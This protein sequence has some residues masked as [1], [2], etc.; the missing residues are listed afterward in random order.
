MWALVTLLLLDDLPFLSLRLVCII[1]YHVNSYSSLFFTAKNCLVLA[2]DVNRLIAIHKE[3]KKLNLSNLAISESEDS[4]L[5]ANMET[6][7]HIRRWV[8]LLDNAKKSSMQ[9]HVLGYVEARNILPIGRADTECTRF[10]LCHAK[11]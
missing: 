10:P 6:P 8:V 4:E 1:K 11:G 5:A 2:L 9:F 3:N 7:I